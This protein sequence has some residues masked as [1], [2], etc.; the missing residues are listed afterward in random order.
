MTDREA[1]FQRAAHAKAMALADRN[2]TAAIKLE[3]I[4]A[5]L[6]LASRTEATT[7]AGGE[8]VVRDAHL[9]AP[10]GEEEQRLDRL[11]RQHLPNIADR[12]LA[13]GS[14]VDA[15]NVTAAAEALSNFTCTSL[16]RPGQGA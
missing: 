12:L 8:I 6:A 3:D 9:P 14:Y 1:L 16:P 4:S 7:V 11:V 5:L 2:T 10:A 13:S 15:A